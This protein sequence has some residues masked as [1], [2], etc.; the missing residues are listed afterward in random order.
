M[1]TSR[2][3]AASLPLFTIMAG[4]LENDAPATVA[5]VLDE[6]IISMGLQDDIEVVLEVKTVIPDVYL[7]EKTPFGKEVL[8]ELKARSEFVPCPNGTCEEYE[9]TVASGFC[10]WC[11]GS[12]RSA[13]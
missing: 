6:L 5:H 4:M 3:H 10:K 13:K 7:R 1:N 9:S 11:G 12:M 2:A 8:D